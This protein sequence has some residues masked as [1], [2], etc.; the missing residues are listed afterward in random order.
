ES[1]PKDAPHQF[2]SKFRTSPN[3]TAAQT[4]IVA[5]Y[6]LR[7]SEASNRILIEPRVEF[8]AII[9][10]ASQL[11]IHNKSVRHAESDA[12]RTG[13]PTEGGQQSD[14]CGQRVRAA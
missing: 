1:H 14:D 3:L 5:R 9:V 11:T 7:F 12:R 10:P 13:I 8:L 2:P 6:L 4:D